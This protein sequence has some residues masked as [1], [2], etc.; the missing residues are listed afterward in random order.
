ENSCRVGGGDAGRSAI[1]QLVEA[2]YRRAHCRSRW[3]ANDVLTPIG[4]RTPDPP[5]AGNERRGRIDVARCRIRA[6]VAAGRA[7]V[8]QAAERS[9]T[10]ADPST[11]L[12][13]SP[14]YR[15]RAVVES[16]T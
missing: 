16:D 12:R 8:S 6:G 9:V 7:R 3:F 10:I 4:A 1:V 5:V 13:G 11:S 15:R 2:G 14:E